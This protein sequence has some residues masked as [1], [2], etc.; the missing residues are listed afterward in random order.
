MPKSSSAKW[1]PQYVQC[2]GAEQ[3]LNPSA[4]IPTYTQAL[5]WHEVGQDAAG[6]VLSSPVLA[7]EMRQ[8]KDWVLPSRLSSQT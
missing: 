3:Y 8:K 4:F 6:Q 5:L 2:T 7:I 1:C